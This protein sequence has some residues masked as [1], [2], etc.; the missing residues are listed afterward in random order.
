MGKHRLNI[1]QILL[2]PDDTETRRKHLNARATLV[3]L[4]E[5]N[6]IPVPKLPIVMVHLGGQLINCL[7]KQSN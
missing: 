6:V 3:K 7:H 2:A 4:L 5:L 1:A